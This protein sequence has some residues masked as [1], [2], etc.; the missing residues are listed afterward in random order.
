MTSTNTWISQPTPC[1]QPSKTS[2]NVQDQV[3]SRILSKDDNKTVETRNWI[4]IKLKRLAFLGEE[5]GRG[6]SPA[7]SPKPRR[8]R[9]EGGLLNKTSKSMCG[10]WAMDI[11]QQLSVLHN[12]LPDFSSWSYRGPPHVTA[13]VDSKDP[14]CN[15]IIQHCGSTFK[16]NLES[17]EQN[18]V[19]ATK[20]QLQRTR[21]RSV[22]YEPGT[23]CPQR[24]ITYMRHM[25]GV[26][27]E[28]RELE[29]PRGAQRN[30]PKD[31]LETLIRPA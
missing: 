11:L 17:L 19:L 27:K 10:R 31:S 18:A 7:T 15:H 28:T 14:Q 29:C 25:V 4:A 6:S 1:H 3:L 20:L 2:E 24:P 9:R 30:L 22:H 5:E 21:S 16:A 26:P 12:R 8:K 23:S 13:P